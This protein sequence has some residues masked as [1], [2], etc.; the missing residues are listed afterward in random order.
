MM[1]TT[2]TFTLAEDAMRNGTKRAARNGSAGRA[3]LPVVLSAL[4]AGAWAGCGDGNDDGSAAQSARSVD[5]GGQGGTAEDFVSYVAAL[6]VAVEEGLVGEAARLRVEEL[7]APSLE[8]ARVEA[9]AARL[10]E[11][12][13]RWVRTATLIEARAAELR[14]AQETPPSEAASRPSQGAAP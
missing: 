4:I 9:F 11:D 6:T 1:R 7:G 10:L 14:A 2:T 5:P 8:R 13:E 12:P 3:L